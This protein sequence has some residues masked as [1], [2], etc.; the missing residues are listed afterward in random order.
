MDD[1][2]FQNFANAHSVIGSMADLGAA[3]VDDVKSFFRTYYAPNNA[4]L[5]V[6]G[7]VRSGDV[8]TKAKKYFERIP[9]QPAPPKPDLAEPPQ[10]AEKRRTIED[11]Q[12]RLPRIDIGWHA[13]PPNSADGDALRV[14][15]TVLA[16]GRS[17]RFYE[18]VVRQAQLTSSVSA[19]DT[20]T[21]GPGLFR[22]V[23]VVQAGKSIAD[24]EA[25]IYAA[26]EKVKSAPIADWEME[27]A[28]NGEKRAFAAGLGSSL[29]RAIL[30]GEYAAFWDDPNRINTY[31]DRL[32]K[33]TAVDVQRVA[34]Q[35]LTQA[36]R[37]VVVTNPAG[38]AGGQEVS[39]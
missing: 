2:A 35:Y 1:L 11:S 16:G 14:L 8:V 27:K 10:T 7:A 9:S 19:F 15:A 20:T 26:I 4:V 32:S 33:V 13:A 30:L 21:R 22:V 17:S 37:T 18:A 39:R 25:A 31:V 23:S 36:N 28:L 6:V 12:A 29:Q 5:T 3:T 34:R 38:P 24:L